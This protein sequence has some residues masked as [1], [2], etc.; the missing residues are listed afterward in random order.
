MAE[1]IFENL[2]KSKRPQALET[3]SKAKEEREAFVKKLQETVANSLTEVIESIYSELSSNTETVKICIN[4]LVAIAKVSNDTAN[5]SETGF[6]IYY[7]VIVD[8]SM[9]D[10]YI[11]G[12]K[13]LIPFNVFDSEDIYFGNT[14]KWVKLKSEYEYDAGVNPLYFYLFDHK[15]FQFISLEEIFGGEFITEFVV[16]LTEEASNNTADNISEN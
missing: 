1:N 3:I 12:Y 2:L 10:C 14:T 13:C 11:E 15:E 8:S 4:R 16:N 7:S 5:T 9:A 6:G